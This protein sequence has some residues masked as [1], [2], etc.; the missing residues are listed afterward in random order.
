M[1]REVL[2]FE[3]EEEFSNWVRK[4]ANPHGVKN[5][6]AEDTI[7]HERAHFEKARALGY[8]P[9]YGVYAYF[10]GNDD[11]REQY[12]A[13]VQYYLVDY[14]GERPTPEDLIQILLAPEKPS[15]EDLDK[16]NAAE[17]SLKQTPHLQHNNSYKA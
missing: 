6:D 15:I 5:Y 1:A 4:N 13:I 2:R 10:S 16:A 8:K 3:S 12:D 11:K 9:F 7:S 17:E 14:E